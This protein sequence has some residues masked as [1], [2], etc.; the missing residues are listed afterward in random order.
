MGL[1]LT[2]VHRKANRVWHWICGFWFFNESCLHVHPSNH[3]R[4]FW[5]WL[6]AIPIRVTFCRLWFNFEFAELMTLATGFC[7]WPRI[8]VGSWWFILA[9]CISVH[10]RRFSLEWSLICWSDDLQKTPVEDTKTQNYIQY[11]GRKVKDK[12]LV[13]KWI[14]QLIQVYKSIWRVRSLS[15]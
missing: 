15:F 4:C 5:W 7:Q 10:L 14:I 11:V 13:I 2:F 9:R 8:I 6:T 12:N 1:N 3:P